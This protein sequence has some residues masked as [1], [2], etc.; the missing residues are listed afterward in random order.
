MKTKLISVLFFFIL[1]TSF[2][3]TGNSDRTLSSYKGRTA[4]KYGIPVVSFDFIT[5]CIKSGKLLDPQPF[6]LS[7]TLES[8][9]FGSG[10]IVGK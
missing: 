6:L 4:V 5:E 8:Q 9:N 1:K 10:K 2:L 7:E 3:V